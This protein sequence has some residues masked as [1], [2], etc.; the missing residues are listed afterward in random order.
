MMSERE[1][2]AGDGEIAVCHVCD[3]R[4]STKENSWPIST[5]S[6]KATY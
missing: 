1:E 5:K 2:Q 3:E 4:F 6:M